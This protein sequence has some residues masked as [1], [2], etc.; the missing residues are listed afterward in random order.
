MCAINDTAARTLV[1]EGLHFFGEKAVGKHFS[2]CK[3][4]E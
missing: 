4:F 3:D 2:H 1:G